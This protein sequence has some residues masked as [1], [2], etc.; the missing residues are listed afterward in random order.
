MR[1][2]RFRHLAFGGLFGLIDHWKAR[3][4]P[5]VCP[6]CFE[7]ASEATLARGQRLVGEKNLHCEAC[8]T[9]HDIAGW[10]LAADYQK[11][12]DSFPFLAKN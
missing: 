12:D 3:R 9:T 4:L 11:T 5:L 6:R 8:G 7:A 2:D 1:V 10:R